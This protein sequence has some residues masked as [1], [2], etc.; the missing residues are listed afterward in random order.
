MALVK[1]YTARFGTFYPEAYYRIYR[2]VVEMMSFVKVD[3][4]GVPVGAYPGMGVAIS[5]YIFQ[6]QAISDRH[7]VDPSS[8]DPI[9]TATAVIEVPLS[10][11][12]GMIAQAY[13]LLKTDPEIAGATNA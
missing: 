2:A 6:D 4:D 13:A 11:T 12:G 3:A 5:Y 7:K 10:S 1:S 8:V 9:T